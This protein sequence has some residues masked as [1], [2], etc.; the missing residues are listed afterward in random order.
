[1]SCYEMKVTQHHTSDRSIQGN[2]FRP[3]H[4]A[5]CPEYYYGHMGEIHK[6]LQA[7]KGWD[8]AEFEE[9]VSHC[10]DRMHR[11]ACRNDSI[12]N[13]SEIRTFVEAHLVTAVGL[14]ICQVPRV[15]KPFIDAADQ[16]LLIPEIADRVCGRFKKAVWYWDSENK[17]GEVYYSE[18]LQL[19]ASCWSDQYVEHF[20]IDPK[21]LEEKTKSLVA[22]WEAEEPDDDGWYEED[23]PECTA[24]DVANRLKRF[25]FATWQQLVDVTGVKFLER[26]R[27]PRLVITCAKEIPRRLL[28]EWVAALGFMPVGG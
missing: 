21:F 5:R 26:H 20:E 19:V 6:Q 14:D 3:P 10:A 16:Q 27:E 22:E 9:W 25:D 15:K 8:G 17:D 11:L 12:W 4:I 1:M 7:A 23:P 28:T 24:W 2:M 18:E 13:W